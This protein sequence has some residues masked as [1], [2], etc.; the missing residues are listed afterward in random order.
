MR[1]IIRFDPESQVF[2]N[3]PFDADFEPLAHAMHFAIVAAG[4]IP[5]CARDL[6]LPDRPRLQ[7]IVSMVENTYYS[8]HDFS[9]YTGEGD[10]NFARF[11][12][13]IELGMALFHT[14]QTGPHKHSF[15][16]FVTDKNNYN[17]F[18]S[19]LK[20]LDPAYYLLGD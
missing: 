7:N 17:A 1:D 4:L 9:K 6:S 16:F 15:A 14:F 10:S 11:N 8:I 5:I 18:A 13:P 3:Y 20:G 12:M 19:D 2:I